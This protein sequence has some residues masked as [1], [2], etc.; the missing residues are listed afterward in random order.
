MNPRLIFHFPV[1]VRK[2]IPEIAKEKIEPLDFVLVTTKNI[3][4]IRPTVADIIEPAILPGKTAIV[5]S[6]NG[7]NIE[8]EVVRRF[9]ANPIISSV[10]TVGATEKSHGYIVQD[11]TDEQKIGPF[12]QSWC[13]RSRG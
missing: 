4:D 9:P 5:L 6:Q 2:T 3:P 1:T 11:D 10:F 13:R 8:R 7:I 12:H